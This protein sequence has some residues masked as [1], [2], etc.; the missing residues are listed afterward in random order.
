MV[1]GFVTS[2]EDNKYFMKVILD[3]STACIE[4]L[5]Q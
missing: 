2:F 3:D 5:I 4:C 1:I